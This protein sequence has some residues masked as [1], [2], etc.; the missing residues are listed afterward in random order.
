ME[1]SQMNLGDSSAEIQSRLLICY[2][3]LTSQKK[4]MSVSSSCSYYNLF[5]S[6]GLC[7]KD[8]ELN[9]KAI[10]F[11]SLKYMGQVRLMAVHQT[12]DVSGVNAN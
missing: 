10:E 9:I 12:S 2:E 3:R 8:A 1:Q 4:I 7:L 11:G 5:Q 6:A